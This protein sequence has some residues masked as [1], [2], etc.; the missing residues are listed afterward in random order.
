[1]QRA[2]D[3]AAPA[4]D[5]E[6]HAEVKSMLAIQEREARWWRDAALQ[7][8]QTFSRMPIPARFEQPAHP[9]SY[10]QQLRCPADVRRPRC[11]GIP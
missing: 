1:M 2:W 11:D 9:L 7:Y 4:V 6:R 3:A 5:R 10:Y 8:F